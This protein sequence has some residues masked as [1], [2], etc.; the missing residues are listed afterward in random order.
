MLSQPLPHALNCANIT[1]VQTLTLEGGAMPPLKLTKKQVQENYE[2][3]VRHRTAERRTQ[4][5][6]TPQTINEM[7]Y[8]EDLQENER[9]D[10]VANDNKKVAMNLCCVIIILLVVIGLLIQKVVLL[11]KE[12]RATKHT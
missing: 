5:L 1:Q 12:L 2:R 8:Q 4:L 6:N 11:K 7:T 3:G 9:C 10:P